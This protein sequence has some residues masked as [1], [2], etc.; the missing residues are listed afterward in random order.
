MTDDLEYTGDDVEEPSM[1]VM[2]TTAALRLTE[3]AAKAQGGRSRRAATNAGD[4]RS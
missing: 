2:D 3:I 4:A 1:M